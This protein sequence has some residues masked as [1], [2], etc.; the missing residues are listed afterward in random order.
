MNIQNNEGDT[1]L[2]V[3]CRKGNYKSVELL[4]KQE[5]IDVNL[6]DGSG[7]SPLVAACGEGHIHVVK[8]LLTH[9]EIDKNF[10]SKPLMEAIHARNL[11]PNTLRKNL[12]LVITLLLKDGKINVN[13][14]DERGTTPLT[15]SC[16]YEDVEIINYLI[17]VPGIII[18]EEN[19]SCI[20]RFLE[21]LIYCKIKLKTTPLTYKKMYDILL[22]C[23]EPL[24][25]VLKD[26]NKTTP[27]AGVGKEDRSSYFQLD[28]NGRY[29]KMSCFRIFKSRFK[30]ISL[31][32][33]GITRYN[34]VIDQRHTFYKEFG[35]DTY[36]YGGL[37]KQFLVYL[38]QNII[39]IL[40]KDVEDEDVKWI[41]LN[42]TR[43]IN[44]Y[45]INKANFYFTIEDFNKIFGINDVSEIIKKTLAFYL[46]GGNPVG[47]C[48]L[49]EYLSSNFEIPNN[50]KDA[51]PDSGTNE[52]SPSNSP[53]SPASSTEDVPDE[54]SFKSG[55]IDDI[56]KKAQED[57]DLEK[58]NK[59]LKVAIRITDV[60]RI[61]KIMTIRNEI[62]RTYR[63]K[64]PSEE[65]T[66]VNKQYCEHSDSKDKYYNGYLGFLEKEGLKK[67]K[68]FCSTV[69]FTE[70]LSFFKENL[71]D[72]S[73]ED[74]K[75]LMEK[76]E[77]KVGDSK[78]ID[79]FKKLIKSE[80]TGMS[81]E[82]QLSFYKK[83]FFFWTGEEYP[84]GKLLLRFFSGENDKLPSSHTCFNWLDIYYDYLQKFI[85]NEKYYQLKDVIGFP[86]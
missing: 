35:G 74:M 59:I 47:I 31:Q 23:K 27:C 53:S 39:D 86:Q 29:D 76:I 41:L 63:S 73:L 16:M 13:S 9:K 72:Y 5:K 48:I 6:K 67:F 28:L 30:E 36:D 65:V 33:I 24:K 10:G 44:F 66:Q 64:T 61:S 75:S 32:P 15:L 54:Q 8:Q 45:K 1:P 40:S 77:V 3:A 11:A 38:R 26:L 14:P 79:I 49:S 51:Y 34:N 18:F 84:H 42:L 58:I 37:T 4:L 56:I 19:Q 60:T 70:I 46:S 25:Q 82:Q 55:E 50:I 12:F 43:I 22:D 83:L 81:E 2:I 68:H 21:P 62:N 17:S 80:L 20:K 78:N 52:V 71:L 69:S 7:N 85:K 57:A